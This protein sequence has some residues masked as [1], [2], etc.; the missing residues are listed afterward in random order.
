MMTNLPH[1]FIGIPIPAPLQ[2]VYSTWQYDLKQQLSYKQWPGQQDL[3]ITLKFLGP[4]E[5]TD[6]KTMEKSLHQIEDIIA[7][8]LETTGVGTFG[9]PKSP[10]VL[11]ADVKKNKSIA[12]LHE[13][14][15]SILGK[16]GFQ[17]EKRV[18]Q[19][20]ITLAKK[21]NGSI[22]ED[23]VVDAKERYK[24][25]KHALTIAEINLYQIF[26]NRTPKYEVVSRYK[27]RGEKDGPI[28]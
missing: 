24:A 3:H 13:K 17:R 19:P 20:H 7:F 21:W 11:F 25:N 10:R 23:A 18:Y 6:I 9:N 1:Y 14:V 12:F 27:L 26:P 8:S 22:A 16:H 4:V 15:E 2:E 5:Q 28:D